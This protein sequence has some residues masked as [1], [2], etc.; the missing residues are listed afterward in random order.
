M[1]FL[2][3]K[4]IVP[5]CDSCQPSTTTWS[6]VTLDCDNDSPDTPPKLVKR[7]QIITNC[8]CSSCDRHHHPHETSASAAA[9]AVNLGDIAVNDAPDLLDILQLRNESNT[10]VS[11]E[12]S[13]NVK[14]LMNNKIVA[15]LQSI[16]EK[17]LQYDKTQLKEL[18]RLLHGPN[19]WSELSDN[20]YTDF[21]ESLNSEH[22]ELDVPKL[23]EILVKFEQSQLLLNE[24]R[25]IS[26][27]KADSDNFTNSTSSI[28]SED[29]VVT[30]EAEL[31][32]HQ[33]HHKQKHHHH[34]HHRSNH[35]GNDVHG[36]TAADVVVRN[37]PLATASAISPILEHEMPAEEHQQHHHH[38]HA[39]ESFG[40]GHLVKG[41]RG[42]LVI[43][44][45]HQQPNVH[46]QLDVNPHEL[47]LNHAGTMVSYG[48]SEK[49]TEN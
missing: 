34:S 49:P 39:G 37:D 21:V 1:I 19:E 31:M 22:I 10:T 40:H 7:V 27:A 30:G 26:A 44:P 18:L 33:H 43:E 14:T 2:Y 28:G 6:D 5:Y 24:K 16:Q 4:V 38:H 12:H 8:S 46:E 15:L 41:P 32:H 9:G 29:G 42:A 36:D 17:N 45:D 11:T 20:V 3:S 13:D 25:T 35:V 23:T 48:I 47:K